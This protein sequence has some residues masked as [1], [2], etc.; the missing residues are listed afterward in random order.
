MSGGAQQ[1]I[2]I[3]DDNQ[4]LTALI[5]KY[6][7]REGFETESVGNGTEALRWLANR[8]AYLMLLSVRLPDMPGEDLVSA[9]RERGQLLPFIVVAGHGDERRAAL[10][11]KHGAVDYLMKD[12]TLLEL[13][14]AVVRQAADQLEQIRQLRK[15]RAAFEQLHE[16]YQEVLEA[17]GDGICELD[18]QGRIKYV[19][20]AALKMLGY[21]RAELENQDF[22]TVVERPLADRE[23]QVRAGMAC[24]STFRSR[25][26]VFFR[27]DGSSALID[28]TF[29]PIR[30]NGRRVGTVVIFK[31]VSE[32]QKLED[33]LRHSQRIEAIGRLAGGVAHDFNNLLTVIAGYS[34]VLATNQSLDRSA[35]DSVAEIQKATDRAAAV[36]RKLL[37][38]SRQ[39]PHRPRRL[40]LNAVISEMS[41]LIRRFAGGDIALT[42]HL[43]PNLPAVTMD[44]NQWEVA[45]INLVANARDA[46]PRGG[47]LTI[48]TARVDV[49]PARA[50][51][52]SRLQP[53]PHVAVTIADTG[54]GMDAEIQRRI[55]EPYFTTKDASRGTGLGLPQVYGVVTQ[56]GGAIEVDSAPNR[57]ARFTIYL[58]PCDGPEEPPELTQ[59]AP[60]RG[61]ETILLV[62]D[63]EAVRQ[64]T[65]QLLEECGYRVICASDGMQA[66]HRIESSESGID[67]LLTDVLMPG[68]SGPE[69][70]RRIA[71]RRPQTRVL[72]MT[73][74][75]DDALRRGEAA[76][77]EFAILLKPFRRNDLARAVRAA[78]DQPGL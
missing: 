43:E 76:T 72:L 74:N 70:A 18:L 8:P 44:P 55:F 6:L 46:M 40:N 52:L 2:L 67:L 62:E 69:L 48:A 63:D 19:N 23:G 51:K 54:I 29:A 38:F 33:M 13:L 37:A 42:L 14:P 21:E 59:P 1:T 64:S 34:D 27:K 68:I 16:H 73:A 7:R 26:L 77:E 45:L 39:A 78:L 17:A 3:V 60:S 50:Q 11:L 22:A 58:P 57:G 20:R 24:D 25:H 66:L 30:A 28:S 15:A 61:H 53:G 49:A 31:D 9:L 32:H 75:A 4:R 12:G 41:N 35:R 65:S 56:A 47:R 5:E 36:A 10:M 71:R